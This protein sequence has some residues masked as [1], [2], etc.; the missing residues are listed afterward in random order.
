MLGLNFP[1]TTRTP[2]TIGSMADLTRPPST[3]RD[4]GNV[5][6]PLNASL[7]LSGTSPIG[8]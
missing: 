3:R 5:G 4:S 7:V 8:L 2:S 6:L 1:S